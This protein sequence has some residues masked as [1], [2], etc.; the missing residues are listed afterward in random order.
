[1]D[2]TL[3][4]SFDVSCDYVVGDQAIII[5]TYA[6]PHRKIDE[7]LLCVHSQFIQDKVH[8]VYYT[9]IYSASL[10]IVAFRSEFAVILPMIHG[11][12]SVSSPPALL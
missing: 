10:V 5:H 9:S 4:L 8:C 7:V 3:G 6:H 11:P 1:M 2:A 12:W